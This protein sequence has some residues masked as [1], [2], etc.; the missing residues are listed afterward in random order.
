MRSTFTFQYGATSTID[1]KA[2][3]NDLKKFTFQY[4]ATSTKVVNGGNIAL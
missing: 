2:I 1:K 4:G 3:L